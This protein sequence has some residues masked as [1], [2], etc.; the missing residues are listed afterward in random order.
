MLLLS[1]EEHKK[2]SLE[3]SETVWAQNVGVT[4]PQRDRCHSVAVTDE[5]VYMI[6]L[7]LYTSISFTQKKWTKESLKT[8]NAQKLI[9]RLGGRFRFLPPLNT[10]P[11]QTTFSSFCLLQIF[12]L[13]FMK[14]RFL[15]VGKICSVGSD[16]ILKLILLFF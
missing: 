5:G 3:G 6:V 12:H 13:G 15:L 11:T 16:V 8:N 10:P 1:A 4:D 14:K 7:L 9:I 2:S